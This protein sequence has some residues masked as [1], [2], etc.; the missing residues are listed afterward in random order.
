MFR[1][2]NWLE[3]LLTWITRRFKVDARYFAK[4]SAYVALSHG[5]NIAKGLTT[6]YL[7]SRLFP[8]EMYGEYRFVLSVAGTLGVLG[9]SGMPRAISRA[10]AR[11]DKDIP[12][13][14]TIRWYAVFC[15]I[16]AAA[17]VGVIPFLGRWQHENLWPMFLLAALLFV[18]TNVSTTLFGGIVIGK[19]KFGMSFRAGLTSSILII[20]GTLIML[21]VRPSPVILLGLVTGIP[22][23]VY[24]ITLRK[25]MKEYPSDSRRFG[26]LSYGIR[27][28]I[29][30]VPM[31]LS[32]YL[33]SLLISGL[34]GL[35]ELAL[36]SVATMIPEEV[37]GLM[38]EFLPLSF[39][40][41]AAGSDSYERRMHLTKVVAWLTL[42]VALGI[43]IYLLI[44][45]I[46]MPLLFP[47]YESAAIIPVT[48]TAA[49][50]LL[51][52]PAQLFAQQL[53]A[54]GKAKEVLISQWLSSG[55]FALSLF[56]LVPTAGL[57]GALVA[58]GLFRVT[59][60]GYSFYA[61]WKAPYKTQAAA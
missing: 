36:F 55:V 56:I 44:S 10:V 50:I 24:L 16:G 7:I 39:S 37:K 19:G 20:I 22:T 8:A 18:P 45:P 2:P 41:Q 53:E 25:A 12:L 30:D 38:K 27:L 46:V 61:M 42:I 4:N 5:L 9:L 11:G 34:F 32:W 54:Q 15:L 49:I 1:V 48:D 13:R 40:K 26:I 6:G 31:A 47:L 29:A 57:I 28:S 17:L 23:I 59:Y 58:R 35:K 14:Y 60:A 51:T 52:M 33:D 43:G 3:K 21:L